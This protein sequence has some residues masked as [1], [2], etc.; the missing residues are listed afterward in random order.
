M[1]KLNIHIPLAVGNDL[2]PYFKINREIRQITTSII[3]YSENSEMQLHV[4]LLMGFLDDNSDINKL[5]EKLKCIAEKTYSFI[6][7]SGDVYLETLKNSYVF[8]DIQKNEQLINLRTDIYHSMK[9]TV[10]LPEGNNKYSPHITLGHVINN[11]EEVRRYL[12]QISPSISIQAHAIEISDVG[13][14]GTC[15][16]YLEKFKL[17]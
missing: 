12:N 2:A 13:V 14:K 8:W 16:G 5:F 4:T 10:E 11:H 17:I 9:Q 3:E 15:N 6:L 1:R 7:K